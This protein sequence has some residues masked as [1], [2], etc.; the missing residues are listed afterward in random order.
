MG[1]TSLEED[2]IHCADVTEGQLGFWLKSVD[3]WETLS[4]FPPIPV[5]QSG[6]LE[7]ESQALRTQLLMEERSPVPSP[8]LYGT[9]PP[10]KAKECF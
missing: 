8:W 5:S 1:Q 7:T 9:L 4:P 3:S 2:R 10:P 6:E